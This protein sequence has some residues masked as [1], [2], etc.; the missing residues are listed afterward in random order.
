[1]GKRKEP[2]AVCSW[3]KT[4]YRVTTGKADRT[5][6]GCCCREC[7][8]AFQAVVRNPGPYFNDHELLSP[9]AQANVFSAYVYA[10]RRLSA[11]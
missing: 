6:H 11:R 1:M 4:R 5:R 3:C 9:W 7:T 2:D 10:R 8:R